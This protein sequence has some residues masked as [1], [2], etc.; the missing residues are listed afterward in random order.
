MKQTQ[1]D[2]DLSILKDMQPDPKTF[3]ELLY[4]VIVDREN[5][6]RSVKLERDAALEVADI[7]RR[8]LETHRRYCR[9]FRNNKGFD[10]AWE[11]E[12]RLYEL[13]VVLKPYRPTKFAD[14]EQA[15]IREWLWPLSQT[16]RAELCHFAREHWREARA[17]ASVD[18][19]IISD[20]VIF[21][22]N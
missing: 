18:P 16:Q 15:S 10:P 7:V 9:R 5:R 8:H 11:T 2:W 1:P 4:Q 13:S 19:K 22:K 6:D 21:S 14:D 12:I 17:K 20:F 3:G